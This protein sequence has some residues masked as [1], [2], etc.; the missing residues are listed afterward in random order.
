VSTPAIQAEGLVRDFGKIRALD[1]LSLAALADVFFMR[2]FQVRGTIVPAGTVTMTVHFHA[3][4]QELAAQ[5]S[6]PVLGVADAQTFTRNFGDQ[7]A[8]LWSQD[9]RLLATSTQ[10]AWFKE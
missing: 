10:L 6:A 5:G 3:S 7:L 4:A 9:G 8:Q 1:H 2:V